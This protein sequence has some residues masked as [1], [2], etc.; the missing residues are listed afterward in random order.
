MKQVV[1]HR[2]S[3]RC[4]FHADFNQALVLSSELN[5]WKGNQGY[6]G[7]QLFYMQI[8]ERYFEYNLGKKQ[9]RGIHDGVKK[10]ILM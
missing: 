6:S 3:C 10:I 1:G 9:E 8:A 4:I 5:R 2:F 7:V